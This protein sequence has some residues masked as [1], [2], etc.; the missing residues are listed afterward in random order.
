MEIRLLQRHEIDDVWSID[1][2]E[3]IENTYRLEGGE[4]VLQ[5]QFFDVKGWPPGEPE[6]G[7]PLLLD[8]FDHGGTCWGAFDGD[9]LVG[10]CVL[11]SRF[12][13]RAKD[14][15]QLK[16]ISV[17]RQ[18][19]RSGLGRALFERAV[20]RAREL[21]ARRLYVSATPS[22]NTIGFYLR[23]GCRVTDEVDAK[24]FALEPEDIHLELDLRS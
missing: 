23:R 3:V 2:S 17:G 4:L 22:E 20:A 24:L 1:R 15:L 18:H 7:G 21:G 9:R 5:S 10:A 19:R 13:G 12:I 11:E 6:R 8:C 16:F 14:Q